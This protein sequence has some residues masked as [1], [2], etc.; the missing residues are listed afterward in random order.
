MQTKHLCVLILIWTKREVDA[1]WSRFKPSSKIFLLTVPRW[2][3][4]CGSF[5][6]FIFC[7][8]HAFPSVH[9]CLV[10]TWRE[11]ADLLAL[12][13]DVYCDL[14][15]SYLVSWDRCGN[16]LYQ[17]LILAVLL[18]LPS[19]GSLLFSGCLMIYAWIFAASIGIVVARY[20]KRMWPNDKHCREKVWFTVCNIVSTILIE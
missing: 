15:L 14:L 20:Y 18:A 17:F 12:I 13:C 4:F 7:V 10:V 6:L 16:W 2:C 9:F 5:V 1:P 3:F 11:R 8:C 19:N